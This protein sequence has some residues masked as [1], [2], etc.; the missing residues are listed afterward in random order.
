MNTGIFNT[1]ALE[2]SSLLAYAVA[3]PKIAI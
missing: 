3:L 2:A 1:Q